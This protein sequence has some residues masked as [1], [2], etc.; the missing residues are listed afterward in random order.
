M[1]F[2]VNPSSESCAFLLL[3]LNGFRTKFSGLN[4]RAT[5]IKPPSFDIEYGN[6][7]IFPIPPMFFPRRIFYR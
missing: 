7:V 4:N 2:P 5:F 6:S 1:L 3:S